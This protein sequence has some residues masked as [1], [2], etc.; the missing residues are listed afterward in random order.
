F[1]MLARESRGD[2]ALGLASARA[3]V[4]E[5]V[6][7]IVAIATSS[8]VAAQAATSS[9]PIVTWCGYPVEAGIADSLA[10]PGRNVTGV[11]NYAGSQVWEKFVELLRE[12]K[13]G[14]REIG[15]LWDYAPPAF[16]DGQI[17]LPAIEQTARGMGIKV[18]TWMVMSEKDLDAA[19][20][21][22]GRSPIGALI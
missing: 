7:A 12:L 9:I 20:G 13:P 21:E 17:P 19:L 11:A 22:I 5:K 2:P 15:V 6:D 1:T 14:L 8:A 16:P 3:L 4:A 10:R 18:R